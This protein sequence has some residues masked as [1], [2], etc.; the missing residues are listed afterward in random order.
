MR[1]S[2]AAM[3]TLMVVLAWSAEVRAFGCQASGSFPL[4][5]STGSTC[6]TALQVG[7][8]FDIAISVN[9]TSSDVPPS[10]GVTAKLVNVCIAGSNTGAPCTLP[11]DCASGTCGAALNYTLACAQTFCATELPGLLTFV[12]V[13]GNGCVASVAGVASCAVSPVDANRVEIR[14]DAGGVPL[15]AGATAAPF[16]TIRVTATAA[17]FSANSCGQ[18]GTRGDTSGNSVVTTDDRCDATATGGGAGSGLLFLPEPTATPTPIPTPTAA[19]PCP[20]VPQAGCRQPTVAKASRIALEDRTPDTR[21]RLKWRWTRG[22]ATAKSDFGDPLATTGY[23]LCVYDAVA[24]VPSLATGA[25]VPAGG[26]CGSRPCWEET[27][28][29]FEYADKAATPEGV[30]RVLLREGVAGKATITV[31]ARGADLAMPRLPLAQDATVTIQLH[32]DDGECWGAGYTAP[33]IDNTA[34]VFR[35]RSD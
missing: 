27:Q 16:A 32:N 6:P 23:R 13:G 25:E 7:E 21:D 19:S 4:S 2:A 15:A 5:P 22:E 20:P 11:S 17:L 9:N 18:F 30:I 34:T 33:P 26:T 24:L 10:T 31:E 28:R 8:T 12:P 14:V 1:R 3:I 29:G 35:D